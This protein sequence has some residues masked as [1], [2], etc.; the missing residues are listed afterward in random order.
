MSDDKYIRA[1]IANGTIPT[2]EKIIENYRHSNDLYETILEIGKICD[3]YHKVLLTGN[4]IKCVECVECVEV[5]KE[6]DP[7]EYGIEYLDLSVRTY[8]VLKRNGINTIQEL[9]D[10]DYGD[11][12]KLH[13]M[14]KNTLNEI[15]R[16]LSEKGYSLKEG[17]EE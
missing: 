16:K 13:Y 6:A 17:K 2:I 3:T 4:S 15:V 10:Y 1:M 12:S 11:L 5:A 7:T 8:N 9:I 14:G